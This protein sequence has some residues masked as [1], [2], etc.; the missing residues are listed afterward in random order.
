MGNEETLDLTKNVEPVR[1]HES[2]GILKAA[3]NFA[4]PRQVEAPAPAAPAHAPSTSL[5][6]KRKPGSPAGASVLSIN[7][8]FTG[9]VTSPDELHVYGTIDGNVRAG[10]LTVC[11]G[12]LIKGEIVAE[13]VTVHGTVDGRIHA[14]MVQICAG[15]IVRGDIHHAALGMDPA[16]IFEGASRRSQN[17]MADAPPLAVKKAAE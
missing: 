14:Q 17:P 13:S 1:R 11:T 3:A 5:A 7:L 8:E 4:K 16:G 10:S 12:G 2:F 6:S 15:G 9:T